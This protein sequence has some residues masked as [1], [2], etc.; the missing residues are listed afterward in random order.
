MKDYYIWEAEYFDGTT[1]RQYDVQGKPTKWSELDFYKIKYWKLVPLME[2]FKPIVLDFNEGMRPI[3]WRHNIKSPFK[4]DF[5]LICYKFGYQETI[6]GTNHKTILF[7][8][9]TRDIELL[10]NSDELKMYDKFIQRIEEQW[11][12]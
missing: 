10:V 7:V 3:Y 11:K 8:Y 1:I 6:N 9:P 4:E 2:Q 5:H 12:K